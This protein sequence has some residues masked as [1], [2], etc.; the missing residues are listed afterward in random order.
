MSAP[1][2]S[3]VETAPELQPYQNTAP[4]PPAEQDPQNCLFLISF[5][6]NLK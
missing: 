5:S 3:I 6:H 1:E 2:K 4:M